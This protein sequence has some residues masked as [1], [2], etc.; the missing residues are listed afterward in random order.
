MV[1]RGISL[2][3]LDAQ[4]IEPAAGGSVK[5][6]VKLREGVDKDH[7]KKIIDLIKESKI[8]V[9]TSIQ[10]EQVRVTGKKRDDLQA[11]ITLLKAKDFDLPLQYIN[12]RE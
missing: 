5:Q 10:Q 12:F 8:K 3:V 6:L 7:A 11:V 9:Q 4:K 2:K 1:K